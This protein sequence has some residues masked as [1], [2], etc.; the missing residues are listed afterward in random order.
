MNDYYMLI[1]S[2]V[3]PPVFKGVIEAKELLATGKAPNASKAASMAGISRSAFY[4]YKDYVLKYENGSRNEATL[5]AVLSDRAGVL[6]AMTAV[7]YSCG[8]NIL[9]VKQDNPVNGTAAVS[10]TI[11]TDN[12]NISVSDLTERLKSVNG[13]IS[14]KAI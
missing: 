1:N 11:R 6:S 13:I 12:T 9:T 7:L 5:N 4:K 3:L 14:I 10:I 2:K 8:A